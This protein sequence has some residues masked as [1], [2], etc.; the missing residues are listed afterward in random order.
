MD[1]AWILAAKY[2]VESLL[3]NSSIESLNKV[4]VIAQS[5]GVKIVYPPDTDIV[6]EELTV[7]SPHVQED[8]ISEPL[9]V[10]YHFPI[11]GFS[12][13]NAAVNA[14]CLGWLHTM[15]AVGGA[16]VLSV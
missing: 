6:E 1:E 4:S 16:K 3:N 8:N 2:L 5:K 13:P 9:K 12:N 15:S 7:V 14:K 10:K 11:D